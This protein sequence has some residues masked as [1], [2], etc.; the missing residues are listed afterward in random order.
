MRDVTAELMGDPAARYV[1]RASAAEQA[2]SRVQNYDHVIQDRMPTHGRSK[3]YGWDVGRTEIVQGLA[4]AD[5][6]AAWFR[7]RGMQASR[8]LVAKDTYEVKRVR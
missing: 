6:I 7:Q 8:R 5:Y 4:G 2:R 1:R 3:L